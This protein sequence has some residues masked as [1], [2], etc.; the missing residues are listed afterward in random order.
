MDAL[1][2]A[3]E[4][5]RK[6]EK[7]AKKGSTT[8]TTDD[9]LVAD[10]SP[11]AKSETAA[12]PVDTSAAAPAAGSNEIPSWLGRA[13]RKSQTSIPDVELQLE[14][15]ELPKAT[16]PAKPAT[17]SEPP[18]A[19]NPPPSEAINVTLT[20]EIPVPDKAPLP[21]AR[22]LQTQ[23][24]EPAPNKAAAAKP[25][26]ASAARI[27][28]T[29]FQA[30]SIFDAK[31][32]LNQ[33]KLRQRLFAGAAVLVLAVAGIWGFTT[34]NNSGGGLQVS[35]EGYD[36]NR[37]VPSL[38]EPETSVEAI[39]LTESSLGTAALD[40]ELDEPTAAA[41]TAATASPTAVSDTGNEPAPVAPANTP[42]TTNPSLATASASTAS[43]LTSTV[44]PAD[45][46]RTAAEPVAGTASTAAEIATAPPPLRDS[47]AF[48]RRAAGRGIDPLVQ[49]AYSE[50]QSGNLAAARASYQEVLASSPLHR[51][52]LLGL[53]AIARAN[54]ESVVARNYYNQLLA[55]DPT[56]AIARAGLL[57]LLPA[58]TGPAQE[59]ELRRLLE[60]NPQ[61][62][63]LA[64]A[65]GN[66][67]A[68]Q[69]RWPEAQQAYFD[70]LQMARANSAEAINPDYAFN[71]AVS[72][73]H[74]NQPSA[75]L[76]F[77][78]Q[79]GELARSHP[80]GFD[81]AALNSKLSALETGVSQ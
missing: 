70:A 24:Q 15:L 2:K 44:T 23:P 34:I 41:V 28:R 59:R 75:A 56:D 74:L 71:L 17:K 43:P 11:S 46:T 32:N 40:A 9:K 49:R 67:L 22:K 39:A 69:Q 81:L 10:P 31:V 1:R 78:R 50:Y 54:N 65:L 7:D 42:V 58:A 5:K 38:P 53:A 51:D 76:G 35:I 47:I 13:K 36:P 14:D 8:G 21:A 77:Y 3:E 12:A 52:A 18:A 79:A 61:E 66:Y 16:E 73:E 80:A 72:L 63:T 27:A 62:P 68:S 55:R 48:V 64:F 20:A 60:L 25:P 37:P 19:P 29:K 6:A 26:T 4:Q 30:R 33:K 45:A 57:E